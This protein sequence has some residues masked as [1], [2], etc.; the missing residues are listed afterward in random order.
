MVVNNTVT[1]RKIRKGLESSPC[2]Y[3]NLL[4]DKSG[5]Q[6]IGERIDYLI[7]GAGKTTEKSRCG[8]LSQYTENKLL[9]LN[10][11]KSIN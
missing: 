1:D 5:F 10:K 2:T 11:G 4:C 6:V 9:Y 7:G 3:G 8:S